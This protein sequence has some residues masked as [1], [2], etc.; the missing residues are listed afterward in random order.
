MFKAQNREEKKIKQASTPD[1][2]SGTTL[3]G[4]VRV[5]GVLLSARKKTNGSYISGHRGTYCKP[6]IRAEIGGTSKTQTED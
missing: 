6:I 4:I 3:S 1:R 2:N 5:V